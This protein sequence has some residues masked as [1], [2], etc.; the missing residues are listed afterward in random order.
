MR[1]II[2]SVIIAAYNAS[3]TIDNCI[4]SLLDQ[5]YKKFEIIIVND[6]STDKTLEI[7]N[8]YNSLSYVTVV[9]QTNMGPSA[10]RNTALKLVQGIYVTFVDSDDKVKPNYLSSL[11]KGYSFKDVDLSVTGIEQRFLNDK[12]KSASDYL[13]GEKSSKDYLPYMI[14][15][16][17]PQ[18]FLVNKLW[19]TKI[20]KKYNL[21]FEENLIMQEDLLFNVQYVIHTNKVYIGN[22]HTYIYYLHNSS[23]SNG[24]ISNNKNSKKVFYDGIKVWKK[25][26]D[27]ISCVNPVA[28]S[29][30]KVNL[31]KQYMYYLRWLYL[32]DNKNLATIRKIRKI[33]FKNSSLILHSHTVQL[34]TKI[35]TILVMFFPHLIVLID[36][37]KLNRLKQ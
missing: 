31:A 27:L 7:L 37:L 24:M 34:K 20:I 2:I 12:V 29:I 21:H 3:N 10:A 16:G 6:G 9:S 14:S 13:T 8:K 5:K 18:G 23:L 1:D 26:Y 25:I 11:I 28:A 36:D 17:G 35:A 4:Q 30:V 33:V 32:H 15:D 22:E 19:K